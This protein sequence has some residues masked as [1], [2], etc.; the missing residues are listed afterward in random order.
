MEAKETQKAEAARA[1]EERKRVRELKKMEKENKKAKKKTWKKRSEGKPRKHF[2]CF[3]QTLAVFTDPE[4]DWCSALS[5]C[6]WLEQDDSPWIKDITR[7]KRIIV[8][9]CM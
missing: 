4:D 2:G 1:K 7:R 3:N 9:I 5:D 8:S 6:V